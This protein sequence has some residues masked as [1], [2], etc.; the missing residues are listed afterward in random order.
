EQQARL[1]AGAFLA[2]RGEL[3]LLLGEENAAESDLLEA[4][5][6]LKGEHARGFRLQ[7]LLPLRV[8]LHVHRGEL[9]QAEAAVK[10]ARESAADLDPQSEQARALDLC[11]RLIQAAQQGELVNGHRASDLPK[12]LR[13]AAARRL[14]KSAPQTASALEA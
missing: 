5:A 3:Q 13:R 11:A 6:L 7:F 14:H 10:Q 8:R 2:L 4:E 12:E 1:P 9:E